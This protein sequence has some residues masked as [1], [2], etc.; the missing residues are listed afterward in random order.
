MSIPAACEDSSQVTASR[1]EPKPGFTLTR[2]TSGFLATLICIVVAA[3][4]FAFQLNR[5]GA[6]YFE[7]EIIPS[8]ND[9]FY[10]ARRILDTVADPSS[11]YE[12]DQR[13]HAPEGSLLVWP[14]GFDFGAALIVRL[15]LRLGLASDPLVALA[16]V[17]PFAVLV[18]ITMA[19]LIGW[20]LRLSAVALALLL[21]SIAVS[22]L[23]QAI[24]GL[25]CI[26]HHFAEYMLVLA[27]LAMATGW[28]SNPRSAGWATA[29][30]LVLGI[31]PSIHTLLFILQ[32]PLL[33]TLAALWFRGQRPPQTVAAAFGLTLLA[34]TYATATFS[35]PFRQAYFAHYL[36]SWFHVYVASCTVLTVSLLA[37][38]RRSTPV[39]IA[40]LALAFVLC[41]PILSQV[42]QAA[43][44]LS[45]QTLV[46]LDVGEAKSVWRLLQERGW[47][48]I[49]ALYSAALPA[50]PVVAVGCLISLW[51]IR[52]PTVTLVCI[53]AVL[54][55]PLLLL[56]FRFHYYGSISLLLPALLVADTLS[57]K[58]RT[59]LAA[60]AFILIAAGQIPPLQKAIAS[61]STVGRDP[62]FILTRLTMPALADACAKDPGIVLA[63]NNEGHYIRYYTDCS[64]IA[65]N[66]LLTDQHVR[67]FFKVAELFA[68]Q[69]EELLKSDVPVKYVLVRARG[70]VAT[71]PDGSH[72][73]LV[74][75]EDAMRVS[76][77]LTDALL[78]SPPS[79]AP[80][81]FTLIAEIPA[82]AKDYDYARIWKIER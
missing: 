56:Q 66:F 60:A 43:G 75:R 59:A 69:P 40:M 62:Y 9:A 29:T 80:E 21:L 49:I 30:G 53:Y 79:E 28:M 78:W 37:R 81:G 4:A 51:W 46:L 45:N 42:T 6:V 13:I 48:Q 73:M 74:D 2:T 16:Y 63:K 12:F 76:D 26:D 18:S 27:F 23:T 64:V 71:S 25:A 10:H 24:H 44:Y 55:I 72:Y 20:N 8:D 35:L 14:W 17:P 33:L 65:N 34:T 61:E 47:L 50:A 57:H 31:A 58:N 3:I 38:F 70:A 7:G 67:A 22:P 11:F 39:T 15:S 52:K 82:P 32:V 5:I 19:A 68:R 77:P 1:F 41:L 54:S 36:F